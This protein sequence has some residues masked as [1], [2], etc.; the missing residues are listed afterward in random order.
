MLTLFGELFDTVGPVAVSGTAIF[1]SG[2]SVY[3]HAPEISAT[4]PFIWMGLEEIHVLANK[5][6][7]FNFFF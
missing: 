7:P 3:S 2:V 1:P 5:T 4:V 6:I